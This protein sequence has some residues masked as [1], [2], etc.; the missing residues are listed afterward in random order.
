MRFQLLK[1]YQI[2][3]LFSVIMLT[4]C[5]EATTPAPMP[6][7]AVVSEET[8]Y[9]ATMAD[10][11]DQA[12]LISKDINH[13]KIK[14]QNL[15][16]GRTY[17]LSFTSATSIQDKKGKELVMDQLEEGSLVTITFLREE[18]QAKAIY[19]R[20][21]ADIY[22]DVTLFEINRAARTMT[23]GGEQ[24]ELDSNVA[25]TTEGQKLDLIDIN[26][27]DT[28]MVQAVDHTIYSIAIT[29]GHGYLR[30]ANYEFFVGGWIEVGQSVIKPITEE[31]LL[32][33]PEG[34]YSVY[35]SKEGVGGVKEIEVARGE[36]IEV[37]V[38]DLQGELPE[39]EIGQI[40]FTITPE[41]A[42]LYVDGTQVDY[43]K[44]VN[45]GYGVHQIVC[46]ADGYATLSKYIKVS[47]EY[48]SINIDLE[49]SGTEDTTPSS[50]SDNSTDN[51]NTRPSAVESASSDYSVYI[52]APIGAE[53][54]VND[55]YVG[56]I[57]TSFPKKKG[58]YTISVRKSGYQTRSYSLQIDD[59]QKDV[60]Y[61]FSE[62]VEQ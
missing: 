8:R 37:D 16:T 43:S 49:V 40:I 56:L 20:E 55:N 11:L 23:F 13:N 12:V 35:I 57:P 18:K 53:L 3:M 39:S 50:V 26:E 4:A 19:L 36:E 28:L 1:G 31:M 38:S 10:S 30:L 47:Q 51:T 52:D 14:L 17:T 6:K 22:K 61:S 48:A 5:G 58:S 60:N 34:K 62:L 9:D 21:D 27:M 15:Q 7:Q 29:K 54:Y 32:T 59:S 46:K 45:L 25:V 2:G 24:F 41:N 33:V 44:E 42:V